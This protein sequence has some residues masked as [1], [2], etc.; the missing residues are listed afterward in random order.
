M[1]GLRI[2]FQDRLPPGLIPVALAQSQVPEL[3][4]KEGLIVLGDRPM[5][6]EP[7]AHLLDD[8]IT[9]A[10]RLFV[11]NNG[12]PPS[13]EE[14]DPAKWTLRI[15]GESCLR[16][17]TFTLAQL[18]SE[19]PVHSL[20]LTIECG[21][22]GRAEFNPP[23]TGNQWTVGAVGCPE[24]T[25][26][27][28]AD[29]MNSC[30]ISPTAKYIGYY[31]ADRHLTGNPDRQAISRGVSIAKAL[32]PESLLAFRMNG[33]DIPLQNGHPLRLVCSGWPA[34]V[35][36]KWVKRIV[37]R[38]RIHDGE[39]MTGA[40][41]KIPKFPVQP[42]TEV[43]ETDLAIIE[44]MPVKSLITAPRSGSEHP[45]KTPLELRGHAWAGDTKVA[46]VWVSIDFGVTWQRASLSSPA[47]RFA[48][49]RWRL[50][51]TFPTTGYYEAW[52]RAVDGLGRSQPMVVPGWNSQGYLNN[53]C[54]RIALQIS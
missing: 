51:V 37:I 8:D 9:P 4:G 40:S 38:D 23:A 43:P 27:S 47:N 39:K 41:Y 52:V 42:G 35:S 31:G 18:Q 21:G 46:D 5:N 20:R 36:G 45:L 28:L 50:P 34:S 1:Q 25:G 32:E 16:P 13:V 7:P 26:V 6:A 3:A 33:A 19:F 24:W 44:A 10:T 11:R 22:N 53:A 30:G 54:H 15:D 12:H 2:V 29:V 48:W 14:T 17:R 49:Q